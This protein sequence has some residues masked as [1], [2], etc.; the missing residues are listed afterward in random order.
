MTRSSKR[1]SRFDDFVRRVVLTLIGAYVF[2]YLISTLV[3]EL[4]LIAFAIVVALV[5]VPIGLWL[6][7]RFGQDQDARVHLQQA[8]QL[9][10][11]LTMSGAMFEEIAADLFRACGYRNVKRIG[12][13]GD[14]GVDLIGIDPKG[15]NVVIQ[16]KRYA[17]GQKIRSSDIQ[18]L[19]GAVVNYGADRGIFVTTSTF[20][21]PAVQCAQTARIPIQLVDG[22][23]L[24]RLARQAATAMGHG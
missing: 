12:G 3:T 10:Q 4:P 22:A 16:C 17:I 21:A 1:R 13:P 5:G 6:L 7:R 15:M 14:L 18:M 8:Q 11:L 9:G 2:V 20:T 23:T 19:M 24:T